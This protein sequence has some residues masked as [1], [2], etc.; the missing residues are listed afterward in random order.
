MKGRL[1]VGEGRETVVEMQYMV[2][3]L[4]QKKIF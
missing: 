4:N 1:G 3:E 2:E